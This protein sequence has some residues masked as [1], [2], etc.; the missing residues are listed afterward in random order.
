MS[1]TPRRLGPYEL[2][3]LVGEGGMG[4]VWKARDTRLDRVVAI[5]RLR[6]EVSSRFEQE[7][8]AISALSHPHICT[9]YDVGD[10]NGTPFLVMEYVEGHPLAGPLPIRE[11]VRYAIQVADALSAAHRAGIVHRDLKPANVLIHRTAGVKLV[12]FGLATIVASRTASR[13][14]DTMPVTREA[15]LVGTLQYMA[16]EQLE[17]RPADTRSD[18]FAFGVLLYELLTGR[19]AFDAK[20]QAGLIAAVMYTE[21]PPTATLAKDVPPALERVIRRAIEKNPERRWQ[22]MEAVKDAL[23]WVADNLSAAAPASSGSTDRRWPLVAGA[24]VLAALTGLGVWA[25]RPAPM[26]ERLQV[27]VVLP[28]ELP[29]GFDSLISIAP[30][31]RSFVI[32]A[33][34]TLWLRSLEDGSLRALAG[35]TGATLPFWSPDGLWVAFFADGKLKKMRLPDATPV[36]LADAPNPRGGTWSASGTIVFAPQALGPLVKVPAGGGTPEPVTSLDHTR[37]EDQHSAPAFLP[38]GRRFLYHAR[39][40]LKD[41]TT[42][43]LGAIDG[44]P[45][46]PT[47]AVVPADTGGWY[48]PGL[49]GDG[50]ILFLR[51]RNLFVQHFDATSGSVSGEATVLARRVRVMA[52]AIAN[53]SVAA[54]GQLVYVAD[55]PRVNQPR[56]YSR[57]GSLISSVGDLGEYTA[58]RL[59]PSARLLAT[60]RADPVDFARSVWV[61]DLARNV[62]TQITVDGGIDDPVWSPDS[63]RLAFAWSKPGEEASN[64]CETRTDRPGDPRPLVKPGAIR[65]PLDWSSDGRLVLYAQIDPISKFDLWVV[66]VDGSGEPQQV[67]KSPGKDNEARF[68]PDG[69]FVAYQTDEVKETRVYIT[70][71][72][73]TDRQIPISEGSGGEPRWRRDGK[74][75]YYVAADGALVAVPIASVG[76]ELRPGRPVRLFGGRDSSLRVWHFDPSADGQRFLVLSLN[77]N[78]ETT[79]VHLVTG[80]Q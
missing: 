21:P 22:T 76:G 45:D 69:A 77:E 37:Q 36:A 52:D 56:W 15:T 80:W 44:R 40:L 61:L 34:K 4:E 62:D 66:P 25:V 78:S 2:D 32:N 5:K 18:I 6:V 50:Y 53:M 55:E 46:T 75:L 65:W 43:A 11:A 64:V 48:A 63:Q 54:R 39:S 17:G 79:P 30:N 47:R 70:P 14:A 51:R 71:Y 58:A 60:V 10:D 16:P 31:G 27:E 67:V 33:S 23:E 49:R 19:R 3:T 42:L 28:G 20:S 29:V 41:N 13:T 72:P 35:T 74:E 9:L 7:A 24:L 1:T 8:R 73:P 26:P 68:S 59:S 57:D 38:D 12:D